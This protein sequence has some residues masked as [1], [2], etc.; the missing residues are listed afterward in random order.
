[1][2]S[3]IARIVVVVAVGILFLSAG[4]LLTESK[5]T[6]ELTNTRISLAMRSIGHQLLLRAGDSTSLVLP[7]KQM[8]ATIFQLEFQSSF[9]FM[10]DSLVAIVHRNMAAAHLPQHYLV[11]VLNCYQR[12]EVVYGYEFIKNSKA[13]IPCMGRTQ[14]MGCYVIQIVLPDQETA[15]AST[16]AY[17]WLVALSAMLVVTFAG[18]IPRRSVVK[19]D[20]PAPMP[21]VEVIEEASIPLGKYAFYETE[22]MLKAEGEVI[23]LSDKEARIL[24]IFATQQGQLIARDRLMKEVWEDEGVFVGRSLDV[25]VSRLRKKLQNDPSLRIANVHGKGY[26]LENLA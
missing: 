11:N 18:R 17:V 6:P 15:K 5:E 7:V 9:A 10:P 4:T 23:E 3:K 19:E 1:M 8:S 14:P 12:N 21:P 2:Q 20:Q 13:P 26:R 22:R 16:Q 24:K 25:F